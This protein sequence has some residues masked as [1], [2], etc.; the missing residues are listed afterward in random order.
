MT[1]NW[2]LATENW[3]LKKMGGFK[4]LKAYE[5]GFELAMVCFEISKDFPKE[6]RYALTD[7]IRRSARS[8][9]ANIAEAYRKRAYVKHY[10]S[11]LTDSDA[12]N[13]ETQVW[14]EFA[15]AC[16]YIDKAKFEELNNLSIEVGRLI[17]YMINNPERFGVKMS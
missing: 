8:I 7:Q 12:E 15:Y 17:A 6:E 11:K 14:I 16:E 1:A 2:Q 9:C 13:S 10:K 5:K 3:Q 4:E